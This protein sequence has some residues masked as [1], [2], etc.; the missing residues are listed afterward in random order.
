MKFV[1]F[2]CVYT[3]KEIILKDIYS[4]FPF[5]SPFSSSCFIFISFSSPF[6]SSFPIYPSSFLFCLHSL[7]HTFSSLPPI[8]YLLLSLLSLPFS[9]LPL[10]PHTSV[11]TPQPHPHSSSRCDL[12]GGCAR[13]SSTRPTVSRQTSRPSHQ[14][15]CHSKPFR[16][17][18]NKP[19]GC[20]NEGK[21][22]ILHK[23]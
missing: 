8:P 13:G 3:R 5:T 14:L 19:Q 23:L 22:K 10:Q 7:S 21:V 16:T 15:Q 11:R 17:W 6:F 20:I 12:R 1:Y 9:P 4:I 2:M 18:G